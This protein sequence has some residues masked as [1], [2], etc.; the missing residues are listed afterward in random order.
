MRFSTQQ[1]GRDTSLHAAESRELKEKLGTSISRKNPINVL[2][3]DLSATH[4][5]DLKTGIERVARALTI[6]LIENP[7][8]GY[9]VEPVY[10]DKKGC[11]WRYFYARRYTAEMLG[12][13]SNVLED[14]ITHPACGDIVLGLDISGGLLIDAS[15]EGF[16]DGLR[17]KGVQVYFMV[18]DLLPL[19]HPHTFPPG[20]D[21]GHARWLSAVAAM[22]GAVCITQSVANKLHAWCSQHVKRNGHPFHVIAVH[23][24]ADINNS[25][26]TKGLPEDAL[27]VLDACRV[28]P[29]FLMVGTIEPRKGYLF[30]LDAFTQLWRAGVDINL[31]IVGKEGWIG[32]PDEMRRTIP[33]TIECLHSHP[34]RE[35][36]L[37]WLEG[38]SDEY[39]EQIYA[40]ATCLIAA[41]EDEGFG[42]PLIEAAQHNLPIIARNIQVFREIAGECAYYFQEADST[43]F[44][45]KIRE[46]LELYRRSAHPLSRNMQW[47][48]WSESARKIFSAIFHAARSDE[49]ESRVDPWVLSENRRAKIFVDISVVYKNDFQTGIQ[50]VVRAILAALLE[51]QEDSFEIIPVYL[52]HENARWRYEKAYISLQH[53]ELVADSNQ[54]SCEIDFSARDILLC[55]DLAGGYV[56]PASRQGLYRRIREKGAAVYF[57]VYDLLP[58]RLP[59]F[60]AEKDIAGYLDWLGITSENNGVLCISQA[61]AVNYRHWFEMLPAILKGEKFKISFFHLGAD[62]IK[63]SPSRGLPD[64]WAE[65]IDLISHRPCFLSVGTIEPRKQYPQILSAFEMLWETGS[66]LTWV[67]VGKEGWMMSDFC[68][69]LAVHPEH[70]QRLLWLGG[71]S[72]E[73]LEKLYTASNCLIAAS[74]DEGFGLPLTEAARYKLP[75]IARDIP[76]FQEVAGEHAYYFKGLAAEDLA[77]AI[78]DWLCLYR[79]GRHPSSENMSWLTWRESAEQLKRALLDFQ[80]DA[81][82]A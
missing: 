78:A 67:I 38:I 41:S 51:D 28:R 56:V 53:G 21:T 50:R 43:E 44:G 40:T 23:L 8:T 81:E 60:F 47:I 71:V 79:E 54:P 18:Y 4:R 3:L 7:P 76:V 45:H 42:L 5:N 74:E 75:I 64:D 22:D 63:S 55:L 46:W 20:A 29:T 25:A 2:Y 66:D 27:G 62:L 82:K 35:K 39:L 58:V 26:P 61:V 17:A 30:V 34:E 65:K 31:I 52:E 9:R 13:A 72:D 59:I 48:T 70:G 49:T 33:Q 12:I 77:R 80:L 16:F 1:T 10:L 11:A 68:T 73:F 15:R 36:R 32:L 14:E 57:V 6:A 19:S 69:K 24:G 37:F